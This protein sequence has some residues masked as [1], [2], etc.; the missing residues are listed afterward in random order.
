MPYCTSFVL[1][2]GLAAQAPPPV[3]SAA[4]LTYQFE[5]PTQT[6]LE[7]AKAGLP[8]LDGDLVSI[9][10][11]WGDSVAEITGRVRAKTWARNPEVWGGMGRRKEIYFGRIQAYLR[12]DPRFR[13]LVKPAFCVCCQGRQRWPRSQAQP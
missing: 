7:M 8:S 12:G 5:H 4:R 6:A 10:P 11:R 3:D 2:P 9:D 1:A 13:I